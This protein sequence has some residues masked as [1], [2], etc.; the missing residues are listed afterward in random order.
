M[1]AT[2]AAENVG[3]AGYGASWQQ[4]TDFHEPPTS[5]GEGCDGLDSERP[6]RGVAGELARP[7]L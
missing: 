3:A 2:I 6:D 4:G 1:I 7:Q 5:I